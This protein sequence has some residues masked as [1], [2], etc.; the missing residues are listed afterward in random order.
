MRQLFAAESD[1]LRAYRAMM[2]FGPA[3]PLA[4][5]RGAA[6]EWTGTVMVV[7]GGAPFHRAAW[8]NLRH[9]AATMDTLVSLGTFWCAPDDVRWRRENFVGEVAHIAFPATPVWIAANGVW[10]TA[11]QNAAVALGMLPLAICV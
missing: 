10:T 9:G 2:G 1:P 5:R 7:W 3:A 4:A 11:N 8:T 6:I